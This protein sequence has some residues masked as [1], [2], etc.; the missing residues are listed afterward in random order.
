MRPARI[1]A[2][3]GAVGALRRGVAAQELRHGGGT[4]LGRAGAGDA[5][6]AE[7]AV[8][9]RE[10]AIEGAGLVGD[11]ELEE[12][13][14]LDDGPGALGIGDAG[15]LDHD[16]VIADLLDDRLGDAELVDAL[17]EHGEG[18]VDVLLRVGRD[19]LRLVELEGEVHAALEVE[20]VLD[21]LAEDGGVVHDPIRAELAHRLLP[22]N[23]GKD[24]GDH[25]DADK[26]ESISKSQEHRPL[27][28]LGV[29]GARVW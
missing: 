29:H 6:R 14:L 18:Q 12:G 4:G 3:G 11:A 22:G 16:A 5:H 2:A 13:A 17:A 1:A 15:E 21:R 10:R 23:E 8:H 9:G 24:G 20:T 28:Q 25:E 26:D 19:L 27:R 7:L